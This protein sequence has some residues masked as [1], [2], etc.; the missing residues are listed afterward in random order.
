MI[1]VGPTLVGQAVDYSTYI[2][3]DEAFLD[4]TIHFKL[5]HRRVDNDDDE[6]NIIGAYGDG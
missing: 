1:F 5:S 2:V 4:Q 6:D 3:Q